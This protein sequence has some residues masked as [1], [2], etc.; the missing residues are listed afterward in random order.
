[1]FYTDSISKEFL[2]GNWEPGAKDTNVNR[3]LLE[4]PTYTG[5]YFRFLPN[6]VYDKSN[7]DLDYLPQGLFLGPENSVQ[8]FNNVGGAP[9]QSTSFHPD[10]AINFLQRRGEYYRANMMQEFR[11]GMLYLTE[12]TPWVF[13]K[14]TG[15]NEVWKIDP[16]NNFRA[17]DKTI[18]FECNESINMRM[19]YLIDLYRKA[20]FDNT[21]MRYMLPD[22]QRFFSM[23][24]IVTEIRTMRNA[25]GGQ[26]DPATFIKFVFDYCEFGLLEEPLAYLENQQRYVGEGPTIVKLPIKLGQIR[27]VN[28]Y[29]L[30]GALLQ[31]TVGIATREKAAGRQNFTSNTTIKDATGENVT[32]KASSLPSYKRTNE[33]SAEQ[34]RKSREE[35]FRANAQDIVNRFISN[36]ETAAT[37]QVVSTLENVRDRAILGNVYN[38]SPGQLNN[39]LGNLLNNP[40]SAAQ[41]IISNF[42]LNQPPDRAILGNINLTGGSMQL[43]SQL[44]QSVTEISQIVAGSELESSSIGD[45]IANI[46]ASQNLIGAGGNAGLSSPI[47]SLIGTP[48]Q[49]PLQG[50]INASTNPGSVTF[51]APSIMSTTLG[52][53]L[54]QSAGGSLDGNAGKAVL[55]G[56]ATSTEGNPGNANLIETLPTQSTAARVNLNEPPKSSASPGSVTFESAEGS[57]TPPASVEFVS[58]SIDSSQLSK[59]DLSSPPKS[60]LSGGPTVDLQAPAIKDNTLGNQSLES[61][62]INNE[63]LNTVTLTEPPVANDLS[64]KNVNLQESPISKD[65]LPKVDLVAPST[66]DT[67]LD[68]VPLSGPSV[69]EV[70]SQKSANLSGV[71]NDLV[72]NSLGNEAL[73]SPTI[74]NRRLDSVNLSEPSKE[75][76]D[77]GNVSLNGPEINV[78]SNSFLLGKE[79]FPKDDT[80]KKANLGN[81]KLIGPNE[82]LIG[83]S[84]ELGKQK[85]DVPPVDKNKTDLGNANLS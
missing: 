78:E 80:S 54:F 84:E 46:N 41:G 53:L 64:S 83:D 39:A 55:S 70:M 40:I 76:K 18:I 14:V 77:P 49:E 74:E 12:R 13:E 6:T 33:T 29:G 59:V 58:P 31:D 7:S 37:A 50:A 69:N 67:A 48:G 62:P 4:D 24:L 15:L 22:T 68:R 38:L 34:Q 35:R 20:A 9:A 47:V 25:E 66:S 61:P 2:R 65:S 5:F 42:T 60:T 30:L 21:Y 73:S 3:W 75:F 8:Q 23:E 10:S 56:P 43:I 44:S 17:K 28:T 52:K 11:E 79:I 45:I 81:S 71:E 16:K 36:L 32:R 57:S 51:I 63:S 85:L 72:K 27:E 82:N 19:T 26:F 1:M